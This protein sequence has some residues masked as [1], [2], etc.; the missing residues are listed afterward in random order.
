MATVQAIPIGITQA[1]ALPLVLNVTTGTSGWPLVVT[2]SALGYSSM[3][4]GHLRPLRLE[5]PLGTNVAI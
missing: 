2:V 3:A 4:Q 1:A 5:W